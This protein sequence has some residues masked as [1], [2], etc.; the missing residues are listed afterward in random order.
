M[1]SLH[2]DGLP[3]SKVCYMGCRTR[4]MANIHGEVENSWNLGNEIVTFMR[5]KM[6]Q[7]TEEY[8]LNFSLI[9]T[10]AEGLSGSL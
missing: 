1:K 7:A 4:V 9:A 2:Y 10:P 6:D 8:Q 3:E 5:R